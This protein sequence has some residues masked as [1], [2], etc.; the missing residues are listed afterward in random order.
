MNE[1]TRKNGGFCCYKRADV[2]TKFK[3]ESENEDF[4]RD[5]KILLQTVTSYHEKLG[6]PNYLNLNFDGCIFPNTSP[7]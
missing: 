5:F 7:R 2:R 6:H 3:L 4:F 1:G